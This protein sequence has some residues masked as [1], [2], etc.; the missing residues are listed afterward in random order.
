M[1]QA[2]RKECE[3]HRLWLSALVLWEANEG[4]KSERVER[5]AIEARKKEYISNDFRVIVRIG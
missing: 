3:N 4:K 2:H 5:R 1:S